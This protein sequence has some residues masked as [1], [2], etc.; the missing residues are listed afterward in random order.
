M[1]EHFRFSFLN[2]FLALDTR[3]F[4]E[5]LSSS[6]FPQHLPAFSLEAF[7]HRAKI[8]YP[9]S[10]DMEVQKSTR[11]IELCG[12]AAGRSCSTIGVLAW[13]TPLALL[14]LQEEDDFKPLYHT[15]DRYPLTSLSESMKAEFGSLENIAFSFFCDNIPV[16][17]SFSTIIVSRP[18]DSNVSQSTTDVDSSNNPLS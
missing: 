3:P 16:E 17:R 9:A 14:H 18:R 8:H 4:D 6:S 10:G 7:T 5:F 12:N 11:R 15:I 2:S 13:N 1:I